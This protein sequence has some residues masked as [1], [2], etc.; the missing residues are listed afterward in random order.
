MSAANLLADIRETL[1]SC[2][3]MDTL[4]VYMRLFECVGTFFKK[5]VVEL[6]HFF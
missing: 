5:H 6:S 3:H 1:H 2:Y 4:K